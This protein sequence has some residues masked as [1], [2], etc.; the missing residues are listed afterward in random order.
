MSER[1]SVNTDDKDGVTKAIYPWRFALAPI[2]IAK[3]DELKAQASE[4]AAMTFAE[5]KTIQARQGLRTTINTAM[6]GSQSG[7]S[8]LGFQDLVRD[9]PAVGTLGGIDLSSATNSWFR[10]TAY[11]TALTLTT[12]TVANIY[13]GWDAIGAQ[14]ETVSD[15]NDE[16]THIGTGSTLYNKLLSTLES[17]GYVRFGPRDD[18]QLGAGGQKVG[19]G[20]S[21]RGAT[22]YKDRAFATSHIYGFNIK[23]PFVRAD[24]TGVLAMIAYYLVAIQFVGMNSRRNFVIT[25][26]S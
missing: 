4:T 22:I 21:F 18:A 7:K 24:A 12:Q 3:T 17:Q 6:C 19:S 9:A 20:P 26:A 5:S 1:Q 16:V 10:N 8:M 14:Y 25:N 23:T 15:I 2:N 13:N 11:T